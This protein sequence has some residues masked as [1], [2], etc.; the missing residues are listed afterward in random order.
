MSNPAVKLDK[1]LREHRFQLVRQDK[2]KIYREPGGRIFV[3]SSTPS[4]YRWAG[5]ALTELKRVIASPPKPMVIAIADWER[6]EAARL[7]QGQQKTHVGISSGGKGKSKRSRGTGFIY[8]DQLTTA[9][10]LRRQQLTQQRW[11]AIF[12]TTA[13]Q[14]VQRDLEFEAGRQAKEAAERREERRQQRRADK[15][16][17]RAAIQAE[18]EKKEA[19]FQET[20]GP[21]LVEARKLVNEIDDYFCDVCQASITN[22]AWKEKFFYEFAQ[23]DRE[24]SIEGQV[25][26]FFVADGW[27]KVAQHIME[28]NPMER[29]KLDIVDKLLADHAVTEFTAY[30]SRRDQRIEQ[31]MAF[32]RRQI[33]EDESLLSLADSLLEKAEEYYE[34]ERSW[35]K[36]FVFNEVGKQTWDWIERL[37]GER[38][39]D[40]DE[41]DI[42]T[43]QDKFNMV[44][45]EPETKPEEAPT[46][47]A[48]ET[49]H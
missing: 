29:D 34:K 35:D 27:L 17:R 12:N 11:L 3:T 46:S 2:H 14:S 19:E 7:I 23:S 47:K 39:I 21:F 36:Y 33:R 4:D 45:K 25:H 43:M 37:L 15:L 38:G 30:I 13:E 8:D 26:D 44:N 10:L 49:S 42:T 24:R 1:L 41:A 20:Y 5:N 48:Q 16:A 9:Q 18:K 22:R 31:V 6:E 40:D 32:I 28:A